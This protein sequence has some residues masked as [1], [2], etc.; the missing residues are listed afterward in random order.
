MD[1]AIHAEGLTK[2]YSRKGLLRRRSAGHTVTAV[3]EVSLAVHKGEL[4]GLLGPN[5]A[6]KTTLAKM[7]CTLILPTSGS[8]TVAGHD[9][10][11]DRAIRAVTGLVVS[12]ERSFYWRLS[13]QRNL[14]FFAALHGLYGNLAAERI[15]RVLKAVSLCDRRDQRFSDLSS[16]MRQRLAIAR[17][18]LHIPK[19]LMLDEPTRSLDPTATMQI[20]QL[21]NG[22]QHNQDLTIVLIT[23]DIN[24]AEKMCGRVALMQRGQIQTVGHPEDLRRQLDPRRYYSL[25]ID[26]LSKKTQRELAE[27]LPQNDFRLEKAADEKVQLNFTASENDSSL[28]LALNLLSQNGRQVYAID[29]SPPTLEE[30]FAHFTAESGA[31]GA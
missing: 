31:D 27:L 21:L 1:L 12:D 11:N 26:P 3:S 8:A 10:R 6:G 19:I 5:G 30:V 13:V 15:N 29:G 16:G 18:L 24:E 23:H 14:E 9:L 22:L 25:T 20:H 7:L 4:F 2:T 28:T 17:A